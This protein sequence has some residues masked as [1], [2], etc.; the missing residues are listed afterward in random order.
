MFM[1]ANAACRLLFNVPAP[2]ASKLLPKLEPRDVRIASNKM[3]Y[4]ASAA[5]KRPRSPVER[6]RL[7]RVCRARTTLFR[8]ICRRR[9][10]QREDAVLPWGHQT[11]HKGP[12]EPRVLR[13]GH[14]LYSR[15]VISR[16]M[17]DDA[18]V[19]QEHCRPRIG[20]LAMRA[21]M[22][23][24]RDFAL[25]MCFRRNGKL[26]G[27]SARTRSFLSDADVTK[28][29]VAQAS[30]D[31]PLGRFFVVKGMLSGEQL[32]NYHRDMISHNLRFAA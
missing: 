19:W 8:A 6:K 7:A 28:L 22:I 11:Y 24:P 1:S 21:D 17:L 25:L 10:R 9:R 2:V 29:R 13:F 20:Q 14:Y 3:G 30:Y 26:F 23:S 5:A 27:E 32:E 18:L 31:R 12:V 15:G 16:E 4:R